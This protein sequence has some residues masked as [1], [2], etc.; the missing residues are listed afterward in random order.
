MRRQFVAVIVAL[1]LGAPVKAQPVRSAQQA[2]PPN[3]CVTLANDYRRHEMNLADID[4][5]GVGDNS[6]PRATLREMRTA[7]ELTLAN[8]TLQLMQA[9]RCALPDR[10]P[11]GAAYSLAALQCRNAMMRM[12]PGQRDLPA[13]C[14]RGGWERLGA[15]PSTP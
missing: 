7:N 2:A 5:E 3:R 4:A 13:E 11:S 9:H 1:S 14:N 12:S 10:E 8:M 6:A 15:S